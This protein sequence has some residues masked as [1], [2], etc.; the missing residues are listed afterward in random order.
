MRPAESEERRGEKEKGGG[1]TVEEKGPRENSVFAVGRER[2]NEGT[3]ERVNGANARR[4]RERR[5]RVEE[6]TMKRPRDKERARERKGRRRSEKYARA[7]VGHRTN[8][9]VLTQARAGLHGLV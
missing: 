8:A 4:K 3:R 6:E 5:R 1:E 2:G 7:H 9:R